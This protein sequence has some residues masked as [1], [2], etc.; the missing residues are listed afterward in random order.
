MVSLGVEE[1]F[2]VHFS[3]KELFIKHHAGICTELRKKGKPV[4]AF[5][6][7]EQ[8]FHWGEEPF[9]IRAGLAACDLSNWGKLPP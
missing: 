2:A 5:V 3:S 8:A 4:E 6:R 1:C 9:K 7:N